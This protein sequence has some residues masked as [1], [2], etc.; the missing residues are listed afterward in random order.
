MV[1][2]LYSKKLTALG[3]AALLALGSIPASAL[4]GLQQAWADSVDGIEVPAAGPD[5]TQADSGK[6]NSG[7]VVDPS[8]Q[9]DPTPDP[10]PE[11]E[12]D[13]APEPTPEP[14]PEPKPEPREAGPVWKGGARER[15]GWHFLQKNVGAKRTLLRRGSMWHNRFWG[16][17]CAVLNF[18][19]Y[20][21]RA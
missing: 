19:I 5:A 6:S 14:K 3:L 7:D 12:P 11:P 18:V 1:T 17:H 9:P 21:S 13:P 20:P 15:S 16:K 2:A 4:S 10:A 8:S